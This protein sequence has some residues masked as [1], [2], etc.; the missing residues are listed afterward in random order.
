MAT[1]SPDEKARFAHRVLRLRE[2]GLQAD[3]LDHVRSLEVPGGDTEGD[4][5]EAQIGFAS[6]DGHPAAN[7]VRSI[8][9]D[10]VSDDKYIKKLLGMSAEE[11][12]AE[13]RENSEAYAESVMTDDEIREWRE[14][15]ERDRQTAQDQDTRLRMSGAWVD[16]VGSGLDHGNAMAR[17]FITEQVIPQ[18]LDEL[19]VGMSDEE[20]EE[21]LQKR[22]DARRAADDNEEDESNG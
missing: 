22:A 1:V 17:G 15:Q 11:L 3:D 20:I 4:N 6:E 18:S 14:S 5:G 16:R 12:I 10:Q 8:S 13:Q 21:A 19:L 7:L 9:E 2:L